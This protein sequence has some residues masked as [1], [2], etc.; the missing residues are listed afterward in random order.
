MVLS[1]IGTQCVGKSTFLKDFAKEYPDFITPE[2]DYRKIILEQNLQI[3]RNGNYRSQKILFDFLLNQTIKCAEDYNNDYIL[4]RSLLD[5]LV[6]SYWLFDNKPAAGFNQDNIRDMEKTLIKNIHLYDSLIYIPLSSNL[7]VKI[8]NDH[9][10]DTNEQYR[11][12][13]DDIFN[14][15]LQVI[16]PYIPMNIISISGTREQRLAEIKKCL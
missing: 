2:I 3:N 14:E 5:V 6:Y 15:A 11:K 8:E 4:D 7:H 1:V 13:I 16:V 9:F 10:R 12:D